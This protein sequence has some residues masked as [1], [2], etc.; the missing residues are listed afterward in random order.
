MARN[1]ARARTRDGRAG[2]GGRHAPRDRVHG[3]SERARADRGRHDLVCRDADAVDRHDHARRR[4]GDGADP[5]RRHA[6]P[7]AERPLRR[8]RRCP[9]HHRLGRA[10]QRLP[11]RRLAEAGL[12]ADQVRRQGRALRPADGRRDDPRPRPR[13]RERDRVRR[14]RR[15]LRLRDDHGPRPPL[16]L[17][18][19]SRDGRA[20][21]LRQR[22][23]GRLGRRRCGA[24][25]RRHGVQHGRTAVR[26]GVRAGRRDDPAARR[27]APSA[28]C[29]SPASRRRTSRSG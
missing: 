22:A 24:R 20:R 27:T 26:R 11:R 28:G 2:A 17:G 14:E 16:P 15:P 3:P 9:L 21:A 23:L 5:R 7:V 10:H 6:A 29:R 1:R 19:R 25:P 13:L 18:G 8:S 12:H 4:Q